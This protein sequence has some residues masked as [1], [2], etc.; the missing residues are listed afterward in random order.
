MSREKPAAGSEGAMGRVNPLALALAVVGGPAAWALRPFSDGSGREPSYERM[1]LS[2]CSDTAH[3]DAAN[4]TANYNIIGPVRS[5]TDA[6]SG[7]PRDSQWS[8]LTQ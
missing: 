8:P 4:C 3:M 7:I 6:Y 2:P 5:G 1:R